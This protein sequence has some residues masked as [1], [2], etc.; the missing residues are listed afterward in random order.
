M[1]FARDFAQLFTISSFVSLL[2]LTVLEIVLGIDKASAHYFKKKIYFPDQKIVKEKKDG[3]LIL[4]TYANFN[5]VMF[6]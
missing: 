4:E 2:T 1:D 6:R 3:T 5:E